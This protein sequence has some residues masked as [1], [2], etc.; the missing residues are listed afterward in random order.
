MKRKTKRYHLAA[1]QRIH[2]HDWKRVKGPIPE[3]DT[4]ICT[5]CGLVS[6]WGARPE[7]VRSA[8]ASRT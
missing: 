4:E 8:A 7:G 2:Y 6:K 3:L 5:K 1:A